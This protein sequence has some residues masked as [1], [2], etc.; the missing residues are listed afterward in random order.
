MIYRTTITAFLLTVAIHHECQ[1]LAPPSN[2]VESRRAALGWFGKAAAAVALGD[3]V[4]LTPTSPSWAADDSFDVDA[5]LKS[6]GVAM[7]MGV[8]GQGGKMR[9]ATGVVL[10]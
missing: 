6:G 3:A 5:F 10:R 2:Q 8:S 1:A 9:P 7:P 4:V